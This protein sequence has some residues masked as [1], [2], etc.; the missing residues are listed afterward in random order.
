MKQSTRIIFALM[1]SLLIIGPLTTIGFAQD[2]GTTAFMPVVARFAAPA[3]FGPTSTPTPTPTLPPG[4]TPTATPTLPPGVTPTAGPTATP[5]ATRPSSTE[6][7]Q[8]GQGVRRSSHF[9]V[10]MYDDT[11]PDREFFDA[12]VASKSGWVRTL[13]PWA[14]TERENTTPD[15]YDWERIDNEL[16]ASKHVG[17]QMI[18]TIDFAP[19][20][21]ASNPRGPINRTSLAEFAQFAAAVVERYDGDGIDDAPCSPTVKH[22]ELYNEPDNR[23]AWGYYPA[24][25]AEMLAVLYPAIKA[26]DPEAKVVFGGVAQDWFEDQDGVFVR[27]WVESVLEAGGG[28]YFD[29]MNIHNY[30]GYFPEWGDHFPGTI[31]KVEAFRQI[32][33]NHGFDKP[34]M[35]TETGDHAT[36]SDGWLAHRQSIYLTQI[37]TH[38]R[39]AEVE[40][41]TWFTL[42]DLE[43]Y[44]RYTGL[45][46]YDNPPTYKPAF[47]AFVALSDFLEYASYVRTLT[48]E[49]DGGEGYMAYEFDDATRNRKLIIAWTHWDA[50]TN[51]STQL[52][53]EASR[54][55]R[56][57]I[58]GNP[59]PLSDASDGVSDGKISVTFD[60]EPMILQLPR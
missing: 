30:A 10:Q 17:V 3:P 45:V 34:M 19:G 58:Y 38:A 14:N 56:Y 2:A 51:V 42:Y 27:N 12:L 36:S 54:A 40:A 60:K 28:P 22:W 1:F 55:I 46:K 15:Q 5:T 48:P 21:A 23:Y 20:W 7:V 29:V 18:G 11:G 16:E 44:P 25:Y 39:V 6:C 43:G 33:R 4:V 57:D 24:Q 59:T 49:S 9:G 50:E 52:S 26:A 47:D 35:I 31:D 41:V 37:F 13:V 32:L 8:Y 53:F